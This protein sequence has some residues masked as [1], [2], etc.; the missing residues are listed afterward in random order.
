MVCQAPAQPLCRDPGAAVQPEIHA[1]QRRDRRHQYDRLAP[2]A[3]Q[4]IEDSGA[5]QQ[6]DHRVAG[7]F[8]QQFPP[9]TGRFIDD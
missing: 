6:P 9:L 4:R 1:D 8:K 5:E 2:I 3:D 7:G